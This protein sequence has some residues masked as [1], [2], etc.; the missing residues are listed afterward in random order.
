MKARE[1]AIVS[2][3]NEFKNKCYEGF[4]SRTL[5]A[6]WLIEEG[7]KVSFLNGEE[8]YV[9]CSVKGAWSDE[10]EK[11]LMYWDEFGTDYDSWYE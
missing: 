11:F 4:D 9:S 5:K 10:E 6:E 7:S 2:L 8:N 1:K 3:E